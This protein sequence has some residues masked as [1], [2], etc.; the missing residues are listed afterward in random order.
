MYDVRT[1]ANRPTQRLMEKENKKLRESSRKK[2]NEEVRA[3]VMYVRKRDKR[4]QAEAL[5][6]KERQ[7]NHPGKGV[8][9]ISGF[10]DFIFAEGLQILSFRAVF[11]YNIR[12]K[13]FQELSK[14]F[15]PQSWIFSTNNEVH[16]HPFVFHS[17]SLLLGSEHDR[18]TCLHL[19]SE[20]Q[21]SLG[22]HKEFLLS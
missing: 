16:A 2:R 11:G 3:L 8:N 6:M 21:I 9:W 20:R 13:T 17:A 4:V 7:V 1:A 10:P 14:I 15:I 12:I 18:K 22:W 5:R 19:F